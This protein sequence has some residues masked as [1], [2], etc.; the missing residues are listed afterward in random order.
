M[1]KY[2]IFGKK[3]AKTKTF[4]IVFLMFIVLVISYFGVMQIQ[5]NR[6]DN[7]LAEERSIQRQINTLLASSNVQTYHEI[8][9]I[10]QYLPNQF[11]QSKVYNELEYVKNVSGLALSENYHISYNAEASSPFLESLPNTVKFVRLAI[12]FETDAPESIIDYLDYLYDLDTLFY[13]QQL[14]VTRNNLG[15][16]NISLI[17]F[18]FYNQ[19]NLT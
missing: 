7:L 11:D 5:Q 16:Y 1:R 14:N 6:L 10:I 17:V 18:T 3:I 2:D 4:Y 9:E 15:G 13:V 19:V 8:G 12:S